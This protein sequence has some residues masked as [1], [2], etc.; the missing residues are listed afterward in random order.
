M[1]KEQL[2]ALGLTEE[3]AQTILDGYGQT[4]PKSDFDNKVNE[5]KIANDTIAERDT[6]LEDLKKI[7]AAG[8][9][10]KIT[11]LQQENAQ[12]KLDH[13]NQLKDERLSTAL[14]LA[15]T[16]KVHDV[17]LVLGLIDKEQIELDEKGNITKGLD[18][19]RKTLQESKSFLFIPEK[20]DK[21]PEFK[22]WNPVG[23]DNGTGGEL[24]I[25]SAFAKHFNE[26]GAVSSDAPDPWG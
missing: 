15:L 11:E 14:K 19:Q 25:G 6:Q 16:G 22:G 5:L 7:D 4:V 18:E 3:Q 8:L 20:E 1:T 23:G 12:A 24:D 13:A 26:K 2:I 9:Q 17:D 10:T 21:K